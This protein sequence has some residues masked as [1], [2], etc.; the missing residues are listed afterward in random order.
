MTLLP[1]RVNLDHGGNVDE[2]ARR[3][4]IAPDTLL[5]FSANV[6]PLG[7]PASALAAIQRVAGAADA[8]RRY[9]D[10]SQTTLRAAFARYTNAT[11]DQIVVGPGTAGLIAPALRAL[12]SRRCLLAVPAFSEYRPTLEKIGIE[13]VPFHLRWAQGFQIDRQALEAAIATATPDVCIFVNPHNPS[14]VCVPADAMRAV[15]RTAARS[16]AAVILDEAFVDFAPAHSLVRDVDSG[17]LV[18]LRSVT[19]FF[20]MAGLR[21][22]FGVAQD[23]LA[24]RMAEFVPAWPVGALEDAACQAALADRSFTEQTLATNE[25]ELA[26]LR[27]ALTPLGLDT[28]DSLANFLLLEL[29]EGHPDS[30]EVV[31]R[32]AREHRILVRNCAR[33]EGLTTR[34]LRVAVRTRQDNK[35]LVAAL[36]HV[37][38]RPRVRFAHAGITVPT[39]EPLQQSWMERARAHLDTLTKP[40]G[41]LGRL[42]ALATQI[43]AVQESLTPSVKRKRL[44]I[45]AADHGVCVEGVS[46][47]PQSV[48]RQMLANFVGGGAAAS[49]L[50]RTFGAELQVVD[51]GVVEPVAPDLGVI[52]RRIRPGTSNLAAGPAMTPSDACLAIEVGLDL[53][54][55]AADD[56]IS[57]IALGEMGIGNTTAASAL[58]AALTGRPASEVT[59]RGTGADAE[60]WRRKVRVIERAIDRT[61]PDHDDPVEV[62]AQLGGFEIGALCGLAIGSAA[63]RVAVVVD[64]FIATAAAAL[65]FRLSPAVRDYMIFAHRSS[66]PGHAVLLESLSATPLLSL[67]MRLGEGTGGLMAFPLLD[68]AVATFTQMATFTSAGV[69]DRDA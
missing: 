9:P 32:L 38:K 52:S 40:P 18:I 16:N 60:M 46:P 2:I 48:T 5:D 51:V 64:G 24:G 69:S 29:Q 47:Y 4:G 7:P 41:S 62:L 34:H 54:R 22:G 43:V 50:A 66:E 67:D 17:R 10:G 68:G 30:H 65:A 21:V 15:V 53:A 36:N 27:G 12:G 56:G 57:V 59:G 55:T 1:R 25:S 42:E 37:L 31:E 63:R 14:G 23:L 20:G 3:Y 13:V 44:V 28:A 49:V 11:P 33:F 61:R 58:T 39:I 19:K 35:R 26:W 6:N 8:L 45:L